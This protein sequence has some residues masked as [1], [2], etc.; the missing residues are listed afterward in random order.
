VDFRCTVSFSLLQWCCVAKIRPTTMRFTFLKLLDRMMC[1]FRRRYVI[2]SF[3][4]TSRLRHHYYS[5]RSGVII[6]GIN[7]RFS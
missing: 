5:L 6:F 2:T 1:L 4:M 3:L 7:F